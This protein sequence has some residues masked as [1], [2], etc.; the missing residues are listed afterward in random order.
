MR[1]LSIYTAKESN[2]PPSP[3]HM[4]AM[5]KLIEE[6][7]REGYLLGTEGCLPTPLGARIRLT[8]GQFAVKD[9]PFAE[10]KEVVGGFALIEAKSKEEAIEF[11]KGFLNVVGEGECEVRQ[12]YEAPA[13]AGAGSN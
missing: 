5:G 7:M 13:V 1:F 10:S 2:R 6:G 12:L 3:E 11:V 8:N 9:G 4:A